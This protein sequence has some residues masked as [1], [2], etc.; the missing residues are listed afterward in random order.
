M[1]AKWMY[2][3][4][5]SFGMDYITHLFFDDRQMHVTQVKVLF[6]ETKQLMTRNMF[7]IFRILS[8]QLK[9]AKQAQ[10]CPEF[11]IQDLRVDGP[12][13]MDLPMKHTL[14]FQVN[15]WAL[16][17]SLKWPWLKKVDWT[18]LNQV[19]FWLKL[20]HFHSRICIWKCRLQNG[21]HF[22]SASIC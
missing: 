3:H 9:A 11:I 16:S 2:K 4:M 14:C 12:A 20:N 5:V 15:L 19:Q 13:K 6:S 1:V 8:R 18:F 22:V 10:I 17:S 7:C 21:C